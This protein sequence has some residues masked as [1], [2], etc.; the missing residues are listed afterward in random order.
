MKKRRCLFLAVLL[1]VGMCQ[2]PAAAENVETEHLLNYR[3]VDFEVERPDVSVSRNGV[4]PLT[5]ETIPTHY[6]SV[7][8]GLVTQAKS[9]GDYGTCW[10]FSATSSAESSLYINDKQSFDLSELQLVNFFYHKKIDPLGNAAGDST[11]NLIDTPLTLG[12]NHV[13]TMWA[14]AGWTNATTESIL[15]YSA[16]NCTAAENG[17]LSEQY[18]NQYDVAH[19][20]NAYI[21][22][23]STSPSDMNAMKSAIMKYGSV[24]C[25]YY[26]KS[27]Y[28]NTSYCSYYTTVKDN[29]HAVTIVGW[30]DSFSKNNFNNVDPGGSWFSKWFGN[31]YKPS[32]NG[33]WLVKNSWGADWGT[34]GDD[35]PSVGRAAGYFWISYYDASLLSVGKTFVFDYTSA[36]RYR[37]N[38]QY[39]GS[40]GI[41]TRDISAGQKAAAIY[42]VK[43]I[44]AN[45]ERIDAVGIGI[46]ST[47][48]TGTVTIYADPQDGNPESGTEVAKQTFNTVYQGFHTIKLYNPPVLGKGQKY[49]VVVQFD[50]SA[51]IYVDDTYNNGDWIYFTANTANDKTYTVS[52]TSVTN[53]ASNGKTARIKAYTNDVLETFTVT[54]DANGGSGAPQFSLKTE[55][56]DLE[57]P[58]T[59]PVRA[60]YDFLGWAFD[61]NATTPDYLA[62]GIYAE[63]RDADLYAVWQRK[64]AKTLTLSD[65][66]LDLTVDGEEKTVNVSFEPD[67]AFCEF[68]VKGAAKQDEKLLFGGLEITQNG[69]GFS[70]KA[71]AKTAAPVILIFREIH[72]GL[73]KSCTVTV[74]KLPT[75]TDIVDFRKALLTAADTYDPAL[76]YNGDGVVDM[77]DFIRLKKQ[78]LA[79]NAP[80]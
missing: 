10:A 12:G 38:Y 3:S 2:V 1:L 41:H 69:N 43:G 63:E 23:Y 49:A 57:L 34:D 15:P 24:S 47:N 59:V 45:H 40:C 53:L 61:P 44:T 56:T 30:N 50:S 51:K 42:T 32:G 65:E 37:Y 28:Y 33:A 75:A 76:D 46:A 73:E 80:A 16:A 22:P 26:H 20:Q 52:G 60:G 64:I 27:D 8:Q 36:D 29:N 70:V 11:A 66:M 6:S 68:T 35:S 72:S 67:D 4:S 31:K 55:G 19:L 14:L 5:A 25:S 17:T 77:R 79:L 21:L 13:F 74:T 39:D 78:L 54:F 62:G 9:Q 48:E 58:D 71:V 18:A 7:S